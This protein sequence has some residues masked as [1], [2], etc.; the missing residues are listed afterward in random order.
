MLLVT[1]VGTAFTVYAALRPTPSVAGFSF[2]TGVD[3]GLGGLRSFAVPE[4]GDRIPI[5]LQLTPQHQDLRGVAVAIAPPAR[6]DLTDRCYYTVG[7]SPRRKCALPGGEG[8]IDVACLKS[9]ETLRIS[10]EARVTARIESPETIT[11]EMGAAEVEASRRGIDLLS[12]DRDEQRGRGALL[13]RP[14]PPA[15]R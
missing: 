1:L 7:D 10:A 14:P 9:G 4:P 12:P 11:I 15:R 3:E 13:S 5:I 2:E 8:R 6:V